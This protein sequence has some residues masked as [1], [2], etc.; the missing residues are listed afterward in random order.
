G[1]GSFAFQ[2][3][4]TAG[5]VFS[6]QIIVNA[7][8]GRGSVATNGGGVL[9]FTAQGTGSPRVTNTGGILLRGPLTIVAGTA[10]N[11]GTNNFVATFTG[12]ITVSGGDRRL[13]INSS[14]GGTGD[15]I[16]FNSEFT[17]DPAGAGRTLTIIANNNAGVEFGGDNSGFT[18]SF[19]IAPSFAGA[20]GRVLFANTNAF[21]GGVVNVESY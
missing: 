10:G 19:R 2:N 4:L 8:I 11:Y 1:G 20:T 21:P 13:V 7:T 12:P 5:Y 18:G 9:D 3:N 6:N 17:Q 14:G 16:V 15:R